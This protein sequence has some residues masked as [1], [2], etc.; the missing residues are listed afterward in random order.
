MGGHEARNLGHEIR[1]EL[2]GCTGHTQ[3]NRERRIL[4]LLQLTRTDIELK[5]IVV[6]FRDSDQHRT[7]REQGL[8]LGEEP[9]L[10]CCCCGHR[11]WLL[12]AWGRRDGTA[13]PFLKRHIVGE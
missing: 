5:L 7:M 1:I 12:C 6:E 3:R 13:P 11:D 9:W 2:G 8:K 10:G 4:A